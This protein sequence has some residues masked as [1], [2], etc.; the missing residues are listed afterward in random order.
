MSDNEIARIRQQKLNELIGK[1]EPTIKIENLSEVVVLDDNNFADF[2]M[3][4][5]LPVIIDFWAP[6]C[7]PCRRAAQYFPNLAKKF[8]GKFRFA[9]MNVDENRY[10]PTSLKV[11]SIPHFIIFYKGD[12]Y[13]RFIGALPEPAMEQTIQKILSKIKSSGK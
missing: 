9:K 1:K 6:W 13:T 2:V 10:I 8:A 4:E 5:S 12:Y 7:G 3:N 11:I